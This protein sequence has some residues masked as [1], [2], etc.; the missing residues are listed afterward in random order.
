MVDYRG[1]E[2][3]KRVL[4]FGHIELGGI[5]QARNHF[6][7]VLEMEAQEVLRSLAENGC[8][9]LWS[10]A[11]GLVPWVDAVFKLSNE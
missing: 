1:N 9:R 3:R 10:A 2:M 7:K 4:A 8:G 11:Q 5:E 6:Q